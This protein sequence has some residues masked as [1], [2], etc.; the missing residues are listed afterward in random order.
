MAS[1]VV[2]RGL[3]RPC[4]RTIEPSGAT[5]FKLALEKITGVVYDQAGADSSRRAAAAKAP[6]LTALDADDLLELNLYERLGLQRLGEGVGIAEIK[7]AYHKA[8]LLYHPD[9]TG[10]GE[11][12][13]AFLGIQEAFATLTDDTKRKAYDSHNDFDDALPTGKEAPEDFYKVYGPCFKANGRFAVKKPVPE[14]GDDETPLEAVDAFY[15]YWSKFESWRDFTL[16]KGAQEHDVDSADTR[17]QKRWMMKENMKGVKNMKKKEIQRV[18]RLVDMA[19][20]KDPRLRR[21]AQAAKDVKEAAKNAKKA[22]LEKAKNDKAAAEAAE[23]AAAAAAEAAKKSAAKSEK[24]ARDERKK[25]LRR[26]RST[27]RK[28]VAQGMAAP[29]RGSDATPAIAEH[30]VDLVCE[31]CGERGGNAGVAALEALLETFGALAYGEGGAVT[32]TTEEGL[33]AGCAATRKMVEEEKHGGDASSAAAAAKEAKEAARAKAVEEAREKAEEKAAAEA[34]ARA[35][36]A[37]W[38]KEEVSMLAKAAKKFPPGGGNRWETI[39]LYINQQLKLEK[40]KTKES[41]LARYNKI[42]QGLAPA[43]SSSGGNGGGGAAAAPP[44][45][46]GGGGGGS[47][48]EKAGGRSGGGGGAGAAASAAAE[49]GAAA[50]GTE[51]TAAQQQALERALVQYPASMDKHERWRGIAAAVEGKSK[52][53]CVERF[54]FLRTAVSGAKKK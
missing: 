30:E 29:W 45:A 17:E 52:K 28:V 18:A 1:V 50:E 46:G 10:K 20:A 12:D 33:R 24:T 47:S 39:A 5:H 49:A 43:V 25:A 7:L 36:A 6:A 31:R 35:A 13:E 9:K 38:S 19:L 14:L 40:P 4:A 22:A 11:D 16:A 26:L 3:R 2:H 37:Q 23:A 48:S 32:A 44:T 21:A 42:Q 8:L 53:Q 54:K 41:C 15:K 51:W 34:A 27:L